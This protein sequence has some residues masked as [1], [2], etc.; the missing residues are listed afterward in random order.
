MV[1]PDQ[2]LKARFIDR[3]MTL[4]ETLDLRNVDIDAKHVVTDV[5]KYRGL[6]Q[7]DITDAKNCNFHSVSL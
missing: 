6:D 3:N 5:S 4:L 2:G 1:V 7:A